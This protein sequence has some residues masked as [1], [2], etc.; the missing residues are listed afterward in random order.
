VQTLFAGRY[1]AELGARAENFWK[2]EPKQIVS[3]P[4]LSFQEFFH[5][6]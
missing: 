5:F 4:Q 2:P 3:A 6:H 1:K